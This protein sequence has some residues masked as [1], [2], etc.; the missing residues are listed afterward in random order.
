[1]TNRDHSLAARATAEAA[2]KALDGQ[3]DRRHYATTLHTDG[4][5]PPRLTVTNRHA[6]LGEDIYA[7]EASYWWPWG[8]PIAAIG[9]P[10]A[11]ASKVAA[12]LAATP[13]PAHG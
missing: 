3:L 9:N 2:L 10:K 4:G 11:A 7:D 12:V 13:E 8:Q 1:V 6:Q 5:Q